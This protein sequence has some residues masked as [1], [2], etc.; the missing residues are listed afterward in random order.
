MVLFLQVLVIARRSLSGDELVVVVAV[1]TRCTDP[2]ILFGTIVVTCN[3][4]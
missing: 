1:L 2:G 3:D 4:N